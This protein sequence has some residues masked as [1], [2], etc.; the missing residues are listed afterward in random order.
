MFLQGNWDVSKFISAYIS[1]SHPSIRLP[2]SAHTDDTALPIFVGCYAGWKLAKKTK[3]VKLE[4]MD[5]VTGM[6]ELDEMEAR[7]EA[8]F[9]PETRWGK[10]MS[11]MF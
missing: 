7:D 6:R 4:E 10:I 9:K 8:K 3:F 2:L 5:F 1:K 11:Y